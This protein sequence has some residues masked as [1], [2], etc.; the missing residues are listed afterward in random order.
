M[1]KI[2][3]LVSAISTTCGL[4]QGHIHSK[5]LKI[6]DKVPYFVLFGGAGMLTGVVTFKSFD[7]ILK[8]TKL[9]KYL[10]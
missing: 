10:K 6:R 2:F 4:Y 7:L 8:F 9:K 1:N 3:S 5:N